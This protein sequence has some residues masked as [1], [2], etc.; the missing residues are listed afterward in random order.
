MTAPAAMPGDGLTE[1]RLVDLTIKAMRAFEPLSSV[2]RYREADKWHTCDVMGMRAAVRVIWSELAPT[3]AEK[4]REGARR[5]TIFQRKQA[6]AWVEEYKARAL[7]AEAD[8]EQW[9]NLFESTRASQQQEINRLEAALAAERERCIQT[10]W[11]GIEAGLK[12]Y[13][14]NLSYGY[15]AMGPEYFLENAFDAAAAAIRAQGE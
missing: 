6:D 2:L 12:E 13:E 4:E 9:Q 3:L 8:S 7:A 1:E 5:A 11:S 14:A 10:L 15:D